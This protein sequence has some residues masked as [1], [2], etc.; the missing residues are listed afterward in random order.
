[1]TAT[2]KDS[3]IGVRN[4]NGAGHALLNRALIPVSFLSS[5]NFPWIV[6]SGG[7]QMLAKDAL[8]VVSKKRGPSEH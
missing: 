1:M 7:S 3:N 6:F 2:I 5:L 4:N 8:T